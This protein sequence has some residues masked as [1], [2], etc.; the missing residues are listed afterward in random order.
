MNLPVKVRTRRQRAKQTVSLLCSS[1]CTVTG[2]CHSHSG[3]QQSKTTSFKFFSFLFILLSLITSQLQS[4]SLLFSPFSPPP[5]PF[6]ALIHQLFTSSQKR[7]GL[8]GTSTKYG[9]AS[10]KI[11]HIFSHQGW[12]RQP[13]R[14]TEESETALAPTIRNPT[15]TLSGTTITYMQR[16]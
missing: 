4:V 12:M 14:Q 11:G 10:N 6:P 16:T 9:I 5:P 15:G 3:G 8:L 7:S 13:N 1:V 2:K